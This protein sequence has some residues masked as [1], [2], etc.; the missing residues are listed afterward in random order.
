MSPDHLIEYWSV[1]DGQTVHPDDQAV[2]PPGQFAVDLEPLPWNGPLRSA[3]A[4]ILFIN[5]GLPPDGVSPDDYEYEQRPVFREAL[6][7]NL[8]GNSPYIYLQCK[9]ADHPGNRW[10][11][12]LFGRDIGEVQA[13]RM[14]VVQLVAYHCKDGG[15]AKRV[16][17][18]LP[19]SQ[20]SIRFVHEWV[21]PRANAGEIGLIVAQAAEQW[22]FSPA[23]ECQSTIVYR[24]G[25]CRG[26]YQTVNTRGGRLL[27]RLISN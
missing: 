6:R 26:A 24:G 25:E 10:A 13:D 17:R 11:S 18:R 16:A 1:L 20:K 3:R 4:Y 21:V 2:L 23:D 12:R 15:P 5:P 27:R 14:C 9:F 22:G 19:S 7:F 8:T